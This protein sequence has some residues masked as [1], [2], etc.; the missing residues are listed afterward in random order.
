MRLDFFS[1]VLSRQTYVNIILPQKDAGKP[2]PVLYLLHGLGD[3]QNAWL[4]NTSVERYAAGRG[5]VIVMPTTERGFYTDTAYGIRYFAH[6]SEELP[7]VLRKYL[8]LSE[9]REETYAAG[10]SMGGYGALKLALRY[11]ERFS[12]AAGLSGAYI[13]RELMESGISND[14]EL[15]AELKTVFGGELKPEDDVFRLLERASPKPEL[16]VCCGKEDWLFPI[17][18]ALAGYAKGLGYSVTWR[19]DG[20]YGHEWEYW[21]IMIQEVLNKTT[22]GVITWPDI[23]NGKI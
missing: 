22:A 9:K 10:I 23:P 6:I 7:D 5:L 20:D 13:S 17:S 8:P 3:D 11:P 16:F 14:R 18:E 19:I 2:Y 4:R 12:F 1:S 15:E 21:D